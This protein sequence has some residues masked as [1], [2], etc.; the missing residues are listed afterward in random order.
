MATGLRRSPKQKSIENYSRSLLNFCRKDLLSRTLKFNENKNFK[1]Q[2][3][4]HRRVNLIF[5]EDSWD[6]VDDSKVE[7]C[8][9][10]SRCSVQCG[11]GVQECNNRCDNDNGHFGGPG[12]PVAKTKNYRYGCFGHDC[13]TGIIIFRCIT[14]NPYCT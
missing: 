12:C 7:E 8:I 9:T 10:W 5:S 11:G 3:L 13:R 4:R 2:T 14:L 6:V 1:T